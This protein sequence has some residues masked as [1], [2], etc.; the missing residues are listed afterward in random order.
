M[1]FSQKKPITA[2]RHVLI[3]KEN[4]RLNVLIAMFFQKKE[5]INQLH[6]QSFGRFVKKNPNIDVVYL[7]IA[8]E[9][10]Q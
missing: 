9:A 10:K 5:C 3:F 1:D 2:P 6:L 8:L 7:M 4:L